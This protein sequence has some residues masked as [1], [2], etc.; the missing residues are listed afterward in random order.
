MIKI[1]SASWMAAVLQSA[2]SEC[3]FTPEQLCVSAPTLNQCNGTAVING[4]TAN[5]DETGNCERAIIRGCSTV[6]CSGTLSC[7]LT[8]IVDVQDGGVVSCS[9]QFGC[10]E[11]E[12]HV[13][14]GASM[15][16]ECSGLVDSCYGAVINAGELGTVDCSG[17]RSCRGDFFWSDDPVQ[18]TA[19]CV[20]CTSGGCPEQCKFTMPDGSTTD[21]INDVHNGDCSTDANESPA[22]GD[23]M[24]TSG[25]GGGGGYCFSASSTV[26]VMGK[27]TVP[28][29]HL[30]IGDLVLTGDSHSK[31]SPVYAFGHHSD[32]T[33]AEFH[34]LTTLKDGRTQSIEMTGEHLVFLQDKI[35]PIRADSVQVGDVLLGPDGSGA[36]VVAVAVVK[37]TG[38]YAPMTSCGSLLV[39][40][41]VC[42]T[43]IALQDTHNE[44]MQ[45]VVGREPMKQLNVLPH[46][47]LAHVYTAPFR[48]VCMGVSPTLCQSY[49]A[50]GIPHCF[51]MGMKIGKIVQQQ[52][53][54]VQLLLFLVTVPIVTTL[55]VAEQAFGAFIAPVVLLF[56]ATLVIVNYLWYPYIIAFNIF[57]GKKI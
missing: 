11:A 45:I 35:N 46:G 26:Q 10:N 7:Y 56:A 38:L 53:P 23:D 55:F 52:I 19:K 50:A 5:C 3:T 14:D 44:Y 2:S 8:Q 1:L 34:E 17:D 47:M 27:G 42:S 40:G 15:L 54:I 20:D 57:P 31:Y 28:I 33:N 49:N 39:N 36:P 41:I 43:Y 13:V 22:A 30:K 29:S 21:C 24:L 4:D 9:G 37:K 51:A 6:I 16:V 12:I 48:L 18:I 25:G 32:D